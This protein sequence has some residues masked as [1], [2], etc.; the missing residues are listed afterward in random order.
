VARLDGK[1]PPASATRVFETPKRV[2]LSAY[3]Q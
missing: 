2:G 1:P 3:S